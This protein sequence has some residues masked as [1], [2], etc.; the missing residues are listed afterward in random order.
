[1]LSGNIV[2]KH[3]IWLLA[4]FSSNSWG[5]MYIEQNIREYDHFSD[6]LMKLCT[7]CALQNDIPKKYAWSLTFFVLYIRHDIELCTSFINFF[8]RCS[9]S[10]C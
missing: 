9:K 5:F 10:G 8:Y 3:V 7:L 1:M 4:C 6:I 2:L